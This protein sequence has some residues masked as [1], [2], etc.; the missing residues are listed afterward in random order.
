MTGTVQ[1]KVVFIQHVAFV[2]YYL[3]LNKLKLILDELC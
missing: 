3:T 1:L 2:D